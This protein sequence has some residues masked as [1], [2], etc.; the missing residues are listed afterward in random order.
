MLVDMGSNESTI[1][2]FTFFLNVV[3]LLTYHIRRDVIWN[4]KCV[5]EAHGIANARNA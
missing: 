5:S 3:I 2:G 4:E 1:D